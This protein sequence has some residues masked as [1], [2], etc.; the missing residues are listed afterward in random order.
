MRTGVAD[1]PCHTG[2]HTHRVGRAPRPDSPAIMGEIT[3][4]KRKPA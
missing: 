1:D 2:V 4:S 3:D